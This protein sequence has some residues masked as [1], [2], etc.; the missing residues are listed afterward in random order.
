[1]QLRLIVSIL[2]Q[3]NSAHSRQKTPTKTSRYRISTQTCCCLISQTRTHVTG[4]KERKKNFAT[5]MG[6]FFL[7]R[8]IGDVSRYKVMVEG[9]PNPCRK[10]LLHRFR[11]HF[12]RCCIIA[13]QLTTPDT[14][15]RRAIASSS[16]P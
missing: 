14:S 2:G 7:S 13:K 4:V 6:T 9:Q 16:K 5:T 8:K 10:I 12:T 15:R 11:P 1:L 3:L